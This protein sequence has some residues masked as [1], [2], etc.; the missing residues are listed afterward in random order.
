MP[1]NRNL[2]LAIV[3]AIVIMVGFQHVY[4]L[5]YPKPVAPP[6]PPAEQGQA[7]PAAP[8]QP[9][10]T[11]QPKEPVPPGTAAAPGTAV[12]PGVA[13]PVPAAEVR[14]QVLGAQPR[15]VIETPSLHGSISL[16]G[17]RIDNITL[18]KYRET[19]DPNSPEIVLFS[20]RGTPDAYFAQFGWVNAGGTVELPG[21]ETRWKADVDTLTPAS[22]VTLSWRNAAGIE[23]RRIFSVDENYMFT[24]RQEIS[25]P[26]GDVLSV[27]PYGLIARYGT[28][29]VSGFYIL[30]EGPLGVFNG[31]LKEVDYED[32]Q[33][34]PTVSEKS[35]GGWIGFTDKY[36]L[37]ALIP[38]Q[39]ETVNH[40]FLYEKFQGENHYQVDLVGSALLVPAGGDVASEMRLFVGAK[41]LSLLQDGDPSLARDVVR[42]RAAIWSILADPRKF[43]ESKL[44]AG[45]TP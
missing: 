32:L 19:L 9:A 25:N 29:P 13:A 14:A 44:M 10:A 43:T 28:P 24:I 38:P 26:S 4:D 20:P 2:I 12:A 27:S 6:R 33:N 8:S 23:F 37:S 35:P 39:D 45:V 18:V 36:W 42:S 15:V 16:L 7:L 1:E 17:G 41:V 11:G 31:T 30:H 34:D 3:L 40:R 5:I 21:A 22:P